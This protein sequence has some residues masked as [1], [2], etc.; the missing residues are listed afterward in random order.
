MKKL[1]PLLIFL[2]PF[3]SVQAQ[4]VKLTLTLEQG[5]AYKQHTD[6]TASIQQNINGQQVNMVMSVRGGVSFLVK[7]AHAE[8]YEMEVIYES[9]TMGLEMPQGKMEFSSE[10][11]NPQD[12]FSIILSEMK[13]K[14]FQ[15]EMSRSGKVLA[16][17]SIETIYESALERFPQL[18][19]TQKAQ[20]KAQLSQAYG[21]E[22]FKGNIEMVTA[23]FPKNAVKPGDQWS[24]HT[25]LESGMAADVHTIY[26]YLGEEEGYFQLKGNGTIQTAD[27]DA[28]VE[29]NGMPMKYDMSGSMTSEI[30]VNKETG[31]IEEANIR[32]QIEGNAYIKGNPQAPEGMKIPMVL[33]N[34]LVISNQ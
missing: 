10:K 21:A 7:A 3:L 14:P 31:W 20:I 25:Q 32:Q 12:V 5:K 30:K 6:Y 22:A 4:E 27:K 13:N 2:L 29:Q 24:I 26:K 28:Y 18:P 15:L 8:G 11:E 33:N 16:V 9:L 1:Y 19:E 34:E 17:H 23:I